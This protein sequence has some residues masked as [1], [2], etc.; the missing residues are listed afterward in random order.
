MCLSE[1]APPVKSLLLG[2]CLGRERLSRAVAE[3]VLRG[4]H[5]RATAR[6]YRLRYGT[7]RSACR[8]ARKAMRRLGDRKL[9]SLARPSSPSA[10]SP[11]SAASP[12]GPS[13]TG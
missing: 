3:V 10:S 6:E 1:I 11:P 5:V 7:L 9:A 4:A 13:A 12:S 2:V 8:R